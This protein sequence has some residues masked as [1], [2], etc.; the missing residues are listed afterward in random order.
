MSRITE[1][2]NSF[3]SYIDDTQSVDEC[4][5]LFARVDRQLFEGFENFSSLR[6]ES[7]IAEIERLCGEAT[8]WLVNDSEKRVHVVMSGAGTSGRLAFLGA[9]RFTTL[10]ADESSLSNRI[11]FDY[12]MAGGDK[13]LIEAQEHA[14]DDVQLA[15]DDLSNVLKSFDN[16]KSSR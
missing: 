13:G 2:S 11:S 16:G 8:Q 12:L 14:E 9:R 10:L 3:T 5:Q 15:R 7:T 1:L 6:S 4:A